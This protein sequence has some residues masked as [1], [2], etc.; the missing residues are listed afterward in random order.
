MLV[1]L[2]PPETRVVAGRVR[3]QT[4]LKEKPV[5]VDQLH[6]PVLSAH[7]EVLQLRVAQVHVLRERG[8]L[9]Q[10]FQET[11]DLGGGF[12]PFRPRGPS[13]GWRFS[14]RVHV[15]DLNSVTSVVVTK[16]DVT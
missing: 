3:R 9:F 7:R 6:L 11:E 10:S 1:V 16:C 5:G 2:A 13:S 12:G 8:C 15:N 4:A 14:A